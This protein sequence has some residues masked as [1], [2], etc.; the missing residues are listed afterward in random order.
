MFYASRDL[1][2]RDRTKQVDGRTLIGTLIP[3]GPMPSAGG[4][5]STRPGNREVPGRELTEVQP[6]RVARQALL[7]L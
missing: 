7:R 6:W 3:D 5:D 4:A 1:I 2:A